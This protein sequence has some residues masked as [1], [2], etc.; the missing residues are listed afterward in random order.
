VFGL[1]CSG[2][3]GVEGTGFCRSDSEGREDPQQELP[4]PDSGGIVLPALPSGGGG[5]PY[6]KAYP[7]FFALPLVARL[8]GVVRYG[9]AW[10]VTASQ[11]SFSVPPYPAAWT[12]LK[13]C[14]PM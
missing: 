4:R 1:D 14:W 3:A 12:V 6:G 5:S 9:A 7:A 2:L 13:T 8:G 11:R 10:S